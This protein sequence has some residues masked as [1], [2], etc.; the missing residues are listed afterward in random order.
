MSIVDDLNTRC[1]FG[2]VTVH[3]NDI[4]LVTPWRKIFS[5]HSY[6]CVKRR[7]VN[8]NK[9]RCPPRPLRPCV[10]VF[11]G[12]PTEQYTPIAYIIYLWFFEKSNLP[13]GFFRCSVSSWYTVKLRRLSGRVSHGPSYARSHSPANAIAMAFRSF[14]FFAHHRPNQKC[15]KFA[16]PLISKK[17]I[18]EESVWTAHSSNFTFAATH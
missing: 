6:T 7:V 10:D 8:S 11:N 1:L 5:D 3:F 17:S 2:G 16:E 18:N 13:G 12:C 15:I 14:Y 9:C 4:E